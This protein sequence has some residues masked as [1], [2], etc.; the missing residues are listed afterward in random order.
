MEQKKGFFP[1]VQRKGKLSKCT[2]LVQK[3]FEDKLRDREG[4]SLSIPLV[5]ELVGNKSP[6]FIDKLI[7][8]N[9]ETK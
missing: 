8:E 7:K 2:V 3:L 4:L 9:N 6:D 1:G 5:T